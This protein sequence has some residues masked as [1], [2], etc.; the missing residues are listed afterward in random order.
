MTCNP[1]PRPRRGLA[2]FVL[3]MLAGIGAPLAAALPQT[4]ALAAPQPR[5]EI[6]R[7]L[8]IA[9]PVLP[10]RPA[11]DRPTPWLSRCGFP[12]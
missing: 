3:A 8:M 2:V 9:C 6:A 11:G 4:L 7:T 12:R 10:G 1:M 5:P